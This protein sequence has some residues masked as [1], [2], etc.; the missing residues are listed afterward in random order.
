MRIDQ[1]RLVAELNEA[2]RALDQEKNADYHMAAQLLMLRRI[3]FTE[4]LKTTTQLVRSRWAR[5]ERDI[6]SRLFGAWREEIDG[7]LT[8]TQENLEALTVH[9]NTKHLKREAQGLVP[10]FYLVERIMDSSHR[11]G[12]HSTK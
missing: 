7:K 8:H 11:A 6:A 5:T 3:L 12:S 4:P 10:D 2:I 1:Q 9:P